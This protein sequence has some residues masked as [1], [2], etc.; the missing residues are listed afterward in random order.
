MANKNNGHLYGLVPILFAVFLIFAVGMTLLA[1]VQKTN[2]VTNASGG[3][4]PM[5]TTVP[6][7]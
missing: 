6:Q 7:K 2:T 5:I 1:S 3:D 4:Q